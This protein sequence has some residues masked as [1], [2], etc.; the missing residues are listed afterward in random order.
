M[1]T[2]RRSLRRGVHGALLQ[3]IG[4][5]VQGHQR[6]FIAAHQLLRRIQHVAA[7]GMTDDLVHDA[8]A[9][10]SQQ[11]GIAHLI[12]HAHRRLIRIALLQN[13]QTPLPVRHKSFG[14]RL[15]SGEPP[16]SAGH[17]K[18]LFKGLHLVDQHRDAHGL[19]SFGL[20]QHFL[21][22]GQLQHHIGLPGRHQLGIGTHVRAHGRQILQAGDGRIGRRAGHEGLAGIQRQQYLVERAV[23]GDDP[24]C[25]AF[26][27]HGHAPAVHQLQRLGRQHGA[28]EQ[29]EAQA[30]PP[31]QARMKAPSDNALP[32]TVQIRLHVESPP[33]IQAHE[34]AGAGPEAGR[35]GDAGRY[36]DPR[37]RG[38]A[39]SP[40]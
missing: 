23:Q 32:Q 2:L 3:N 17:G 29:T 36:A 15:A 5:R 4:F 18:K 16:Q 14:A 22:S 37:H 27:T 7:T 24:L 9:S 25:G 26:Q 10:G 11:V 34:A 40:P 21:T 1:R 6:L 20:G 35:C 12:E 28:T 39:G 33:G 8:D 30:Q 31:P 13:R 38:R 19:Q